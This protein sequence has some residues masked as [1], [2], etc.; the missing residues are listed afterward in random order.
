V[1]GVAVQVSGQQSQENRYDNA[2]AL[3]NSSESGGVERACD[4]MQQLA[5]ESPSNQTYQTAKR[6][7]C[8]QARLILDTESQAAQNGNEAARRGRCSEARTY[9][10]QIL[11]LATRSPTYR[12]KLNAEIRDCEARLQQQTNNGR[13]QQGV[14]SSNDVLKAGLRAYFAGDL[15]TAEGDF[16]AYLGNPGDHEALAFFFRGTT[17][18]SL[19]YLSGE[20]D[21]SSRNSAVADFHNLKMRYRTFNAPVQYVSPKIRDFYN[22]QQ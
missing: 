5:Q 18:L 11:Q 3:F 1:A 21:F 2:V 12:N 7:F 17:M 14:P 9:Y 6:T 20:T 10:Q 19:Y 15:K 8:N 22:A 13:A 16:T 4:I